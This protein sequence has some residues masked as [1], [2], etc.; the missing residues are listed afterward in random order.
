MLL[1]V[2]TPPALILFA[3]E[4]APGQ[5]KTRLIPLLGAEGA[6]ELYRR[7]L[8]DCAET[9][10]DQP[11]ALYVAVSESSAVETVRALLS[12]VCPEAEFVAQSG[13]DLGARM[14]TAVEAA[15]AQGHPGV[16]V[17]GSDAPSLPGSRIREALQGCARCDLVLGPAFDGGYYLIGMPRV[18]REC[19]EGLSWG[20]STVL[21]DTLR[22]AREVG[23]K[24]SLLA[25]WYDVDTPEDL[26]TLR[27][28]LTALHLAGEPIPCP[29]TWEYLQAQ[30][31]EVRD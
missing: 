31:T 22:R 21:V 4:P 17:I 26:Q 30:A 18:I 5:A 29:R 7:F 24:V 19:F 12:P 27:S 3:R 14:G 2:S 1:D 20:E 9:A 8:L 10:A 23:A 11:A 6:A 16:V 13:A 28:H 25:P 15:L